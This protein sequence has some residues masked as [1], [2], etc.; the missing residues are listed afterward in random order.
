MIDQP[1]KNTATNEQGQFG[2]KGI[3]EG[4]IRLQANFSSS[5][6]GAG[7]TSAQ[8]GD[9]NIKIILG[10]TLVHTPP[11][12]SLI[13]KSLPDI[14]NLGIKPENANAKAILICFFDMEQ[15]PSRNCIM[16]L[17]KKAQDFQAKD[18]V[19]VS[20]QTSKIEQVKLDEWVKENNIPFPVGMIEGD[21][22][23]TQLAWG[24]KSLPW[25]ILAD[26]QHI[27]SAEGFSLN[28]IDEKIKTLTEK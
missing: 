15:R 11:H 24:V 8:A 6:G 18:I 13:G 7:F 2:I 12:Q 3:A 23:K 5:P 1:E 4:P 17:D 28:E 26:K 25:L 22:E 20:I 14:S 19:V 27:V 21:S 9:Q 16:Q 10:Q